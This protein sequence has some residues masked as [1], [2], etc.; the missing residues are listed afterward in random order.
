VGEGRRRRRRV[1]IR[2][3]RRLMVTAKKYRWTTGTGTKSKS[4]KGKKLKPTTTTATSA[5]GDETSGLASATTIQSSMKK[6]SSRL[7]RSRMRFVLWRARCRVRKRW[8]CCG[9]SGGDILLFPR[10]DG[11][12]IGLLGTLRDRGR[13]I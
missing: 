6:R 10:V 11:M 4:A 13:P 8:F 3:Q 9:E 5:S 1:V 2:R 12:K 7:R